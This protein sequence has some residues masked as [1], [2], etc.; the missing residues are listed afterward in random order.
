MELQGAGFGGDSERK[1]Y[2]LGYYTTI[3]GVFG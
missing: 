2:L 1:G 3:P